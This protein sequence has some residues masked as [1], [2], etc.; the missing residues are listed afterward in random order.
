MSKLFAN[1]L[2]SICEY[3]DVNIIDVLG[4]RRFKELVKARSMFCFIMNRLHLSGNT[5]VLSNGKLKDESLFTQVRIA[6]FLN[7]SN[8]TTVSI[9]IKKI[10]QDIE[11]GVKSTIKEIED[12]LDMIGDD[13]MKSIFESIKQSLT[14]ERIRLK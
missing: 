10:E 2:T 13:D 11:I 7:Y 6:S 4:R 12:I 5:M 14:K 1:R 9:F 8:H 3:Y